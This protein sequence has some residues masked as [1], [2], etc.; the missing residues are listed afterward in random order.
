MEEM[1]KFFQ[2]DLFARH[3]GIE[4]LEVTEGKARAK[5]PIKDFHFNSLG[6]VHGGAI[7]SLADF[8]FAAASNSYGTMAVAINVCISYLRAARGGTLFADAREVSR[9]PKLASYAIS[10]KDDASNL[11]AI[12]QGMVYR[13]KDQIALPRGRKSKE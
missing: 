3:L 11:V 10:I 2:R 5:M 1:K 7:F 9:N 12:F 6:S 8:V 4:L 13:K